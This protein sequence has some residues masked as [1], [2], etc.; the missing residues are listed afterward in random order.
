M[1]VGY[2]PKG[3]AVRLHLYLL[4]LSSKN[5]LRPFSTYFLWNFKFILQRSYSIVYAIY[6]PVNG[7]L[8]DDGRCSDPRRH[9]SRDQFT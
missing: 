7:P 2:Q 1:Q 6:F 3:S 8:E 5:W 9:M 4:K